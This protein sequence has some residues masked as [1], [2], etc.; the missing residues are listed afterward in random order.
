MDVSIIIVNYNTWQDLR[1]CLDSLYAQTKGVSF[2]V[3]VVDNCSNVENIKHLRQEETRAKI[4][5]NKK[6]SGFGIANNIGITAAKGDY[7]FLLNS[8]TI[9]QN[10]AIKIFFEKMKAYSLPPVYNN[11]SRQLNIYSL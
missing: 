5:Y 10:N 6:N 9:L 7:L 2:E 8:D 1:N 4:I 3:I 11:Q